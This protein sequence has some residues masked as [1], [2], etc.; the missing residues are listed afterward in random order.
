MRGNDAF[1]IDTD[2][3]QPGVSTLAAV[4]M[5][6][7]YEGTTMVDLMMPNHTTTFGHTRAVEDHRTMK[8][9]FCLL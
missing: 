5:V 3:S 6:G 9:Y 1:S 7:G 2:K 8:Y 4:E